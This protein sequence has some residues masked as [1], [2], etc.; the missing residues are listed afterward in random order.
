MVNLITTDKKGE[1]V[2]K[3]NDIRY[4]IFLAGPTLRT[5]QIAWREDA[6]KLFEEYADIDVSLV[7]PEP[8]MGDYAEQ[9]EFEHYHIQTSDLIFFWVPRDIENK[10]YGLTT[11]VEFG[12]FMPLAFRAISNPILYGRPEDSDNNRYLDYCYRKFY[13]QEPLDRLDK[14]V[15]I[16]LQKVIINK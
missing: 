4:K 11:N 9:I 5:N 7:I 16:A 14:M 2:H 6:I 12:M 3:E 8:F 13:K 15:A 10:V 1:L